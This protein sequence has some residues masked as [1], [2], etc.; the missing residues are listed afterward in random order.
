[1]DVNLFMD[2]HL[3]NITKLMG[4]KIKKSKTFTHSQSKAVISFGGPNSNSN[5]NLKVVLASS[6]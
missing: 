5:H 4:K 3:S 2:Y 1:M 6:K